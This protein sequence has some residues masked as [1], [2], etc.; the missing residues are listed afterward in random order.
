[1][2]RLVPVV[3]VDYKK[4]PKTIDDLTIDSS[5]VCKLNQIINIL[6][7]DS[8]EFVPSGA[9][10]VQFFTLSW[11]DRC[12]EYYFV[13]F[14]DLFNVFFAQYVSYFLEFWQST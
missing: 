13:S 9:S 4:R 3:I 5:K 14:P 2:L 11:I 8:N 10:M 6:K 7:Q 12:L 1:M